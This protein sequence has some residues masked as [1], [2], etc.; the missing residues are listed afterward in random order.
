MFIIASS[1]VIRLSQGKLGIDLIVDVKG[2]GDDTVI[3]TLARPSKPYHLLTV[4]EQSLVVEYHSSPNRATS[5]FELFEQE[6]SGTVLVRCFA[7][8]KKKQYYLNL[9]PDGS[10][11][12]LRCSGDMIPVFRIETPRVSAKVS[13]LQ[14]AGWQT[15]RFVLEGY[16][17][18]AA[19]VPEAQVDE[20]LHLIN[21]ELGKVGALVAGGLQE[22]YGKLDG[23]FSNHET[24]RNL[25]LLDARPYIDLFLGDDNLTTSH[26][27]A[28]IALRFPQVRAGSGDN[29]N[30]SDLVWHTDGLRQGRRH[31]FSLLLGVA[32][33]D[34]T[35]TECGNLLLW[36][37]SHVLIHRATVD[38]CGRIDCALLETLLTK[39]A[40]HFNL[41]VEST[42]TAAVSLDCEPSEVHDNEPQLPRLGPPLTMQM[43]RGDVV[44]LHPDLAHCGG[45]NYSSSL[46]YMVYFRLRSLKRDSATGDACVWSEVSE[47]FEDDL[48]T[49][50]PGVRDAA[51]RLGDVLNSRLTA[52]IVNK[53]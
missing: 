31:N 33:S 24:L 12:A 36:P 6:P 7:Y 52:D 21:Q 41:S 18:I 19:V 13:R 23:R 3:V 35:S 48:W 5:V 42:T 27:A 26:L 38:D 20:C 25:A 50:L 45:P 11:I 29:T 9:T 49:D 37:G 4:S 43:R 46:R 8:D 32:L 16:L 40:D 1:D 15:D 51:H 39:N 34:M 22:G 10:L 14:L 28:Q 53:Y 30:N 44:L 47:A 17:H 2:K